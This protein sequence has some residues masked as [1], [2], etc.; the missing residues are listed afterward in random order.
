MKTILKKI[1]GKGALLAVAL[2]MG[3]NSA[4]AADTDYTEVADSTAAEFF[5]SAPL[6]IFPTIDRTTRLDMIDYFDAGSDKPSSNAIGGECKI[7]SKTPESLTF[8]T[9]EISE[10]TLSVIPSTKKS[11]DPIIM[12]VRTLKTPAE[13]STVKF[14]SS[15]WKELDGIFEVPMLRDWLNDAGKQ[16]RKDVENAVPFVLAK[17]AYDPASQSLTLTNQLADYLPEEALGLAKESLHQQLHFRWNGRKFV[18]VKQK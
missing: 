7:L 8:T 6:S 11:G 1:L 3:A 15:H 13:D 2:L 10:Y 12:V 18:I 9:S 5:A 14:Y 16:Q 17:L 4:V